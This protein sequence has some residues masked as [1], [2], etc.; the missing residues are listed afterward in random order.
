MKESRPIK[1]LS[2]MKLAEAIR[3]VNEATER[4]QLV[5]SLVLENLG[6]ASAQITGVETEQLLVHLELPD[7]QEEK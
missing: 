6:I 5:A 3:G 4:Y 7:I 1:P 2:A